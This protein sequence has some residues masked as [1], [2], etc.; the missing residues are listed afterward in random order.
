M[1]LPASGAI[2]LS[3]VSA[4]IGGG[5]TGS[6]SLAWVRDSTYYAYKDLNSIHGLTWFR[7]YSSNG[8]V[9]RSPL[10]TTTNCAVNCDNQNNSSGYDGIGGWTNC[11]PT[12]NVNC[13]QC[14]VDHGAYLQGNCNCACNCHVCN[15]EYSN[16]NCNC[17]CACG[18]GGGGA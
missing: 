13:N 14:G 7:A 6:V 18:D 2:S 10:V 9:V 12:V 1:T 3:N 5:P 11:N 16:C 4:E 8:N 17:A 15:C